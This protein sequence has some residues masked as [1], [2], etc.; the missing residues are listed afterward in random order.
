MMNFVQILAEASGAV[1]VTA[2]EAA[3]AASETTATATGAAG[4]GGL[5]STVIMMVVMVAVF[6][7]LLIR[8]QRKKDKQVKDMLA[9]L[10]PGD[11]ICTIGGIYGTIASIKDETIVLYVGA[12]K[13]Q[14]VV[15]RWAIRSV[16]DA[17]L[18]ENESEA[19]V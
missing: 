12:Q 10:K 15:A 13:L 7:F 2:P 11:R 18:V 6:Y 9:A 17:P 3:S 8:P 16:E 5:L 14:M 4:A 1:A 19:L